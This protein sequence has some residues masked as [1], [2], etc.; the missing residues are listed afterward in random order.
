[1]QKQSLISICIPVFQTESFLAQC[2]RSVITQDFDAFEI[3]VLSDAS[4]GKDLQ[5]YNARKI[6]RLMQKEC[7]VYRKKNQLPPIRINYIEHSQNRG[8]FEVR[9]TLC[10]NAKSRYICYVDS[11]DELEPGALTALYQAAIQ[12]DSDIIH[13]ASTAGYFDRECNFFPLEKNHFNLRYDGRIEHEQLF[14]SWLMRKKFSGML[15]SKLFSRDLLLKVYDNIP[16]T[17]CN[18]ADDFLLMFFITQFA[19]RY[20]GISQKI[21]R[22]RMGQGMT[23]SRKIQTLARWKMICSAASVFSIISMW[24]EEHKASETPH[25]F[26]Q[27]EILALRHFSAHYV[28]NALTQLHETVIPELQEQA[29]QLLCEFWGKSLVDRI[30]EENNQN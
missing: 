10:Y 4:D 22:Y 15:W 1:M 17:E 3:L 28:Q 16:Y 29:Y 21:Y 2:L 27:E 6:V 9:R 13:G 25:A 30:N 7:G 5:N 19:N 18:M 20:T 14:N 8:V 12:N 24:I 11:D 26:T 23:N